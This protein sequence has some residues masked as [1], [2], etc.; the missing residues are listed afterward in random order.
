MSC[1]KVKVIG[2]GHKDK[3]LIFKDLMCLTCDLVVKVKGH[4]VVVK[5]HIGQGQIRSTINNLY[6]CVL[7][8]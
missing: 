2:Q 6:Y 4:C 1:V 3:K 8:K 5:D 7:F